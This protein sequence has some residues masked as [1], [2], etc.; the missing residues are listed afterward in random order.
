M[1]RTLTIFAL[2]LT[3]MTMS[4]ACSAIKR[5]S[6]ARSAIFAQSTDRKNS[7]PVNIVAEKLY[8]QIDQ[9]YSNHDVKKLLDFYDP[10]FTLIDEKDKHIDFAEYR[11]QVTIDFENEQL[12]N[13]Y[14]KTSIKDARLQEGR[15][16]VY[17]D[18]TTRF[19]FRD[20]RYGWENWINLASTETT[21]KKTGDQWKMVNSHT[22]KASSGIDPQWFA[23]HRQDLQNQIRGIQRAADSVLR[24]CTQSARG[25]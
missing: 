1:F 17:F 7:E 19:E 23:Q 6:A 8:D 3:T 5:A 9:S 13:F 11:K 10:S 15:L 20:P 2:A 21:W 25:C 16:V 18:S 12:K 14:K 22:L 4:V 24:P